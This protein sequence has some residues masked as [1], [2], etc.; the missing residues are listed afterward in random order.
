[1][2]QVAC[3]GQTAD[4]DCFMRLVILV[5]A[6]SLFAAASST[7]AAAELPLYQSLDHPLKYRLGI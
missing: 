6:V 1:M 3:F 4:H 5:L 7:V 2:H